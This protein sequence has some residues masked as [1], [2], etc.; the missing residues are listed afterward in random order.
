MPRL[1]F[2]GAAF[3]W[4]LLLLVA[5]A[6]PLERTWVLWPTWL[7]VACV[8]IAIGIGY[9][10]GVVSNASVAIATV[11]GVGTFVSGFYGMRF[12]RSTASARDGS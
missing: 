6:R 2:A 10:G 12:A 1:Q 8:L 3:A 5:S 4:G 7:A 9:A 11:L